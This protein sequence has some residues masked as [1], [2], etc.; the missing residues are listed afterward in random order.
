LSTW[1]DNYVEGLIECFGTSNIYELYDYLD[2]RILKMDRENILLQ[3][4]EAI[5]HRDY[6][7]HELVFIRND[8]DRSYEKKILAHELGHAIIHTNI[9]VAAYNNPLFNFGKMEAQANYFAS[10]LLGRDISN[11]ILEDSN[12]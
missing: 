7:S 12:A 6:T 2:I 8:L 3:G 1:I 10:K 5:Y 11:E 9:Y 4:N